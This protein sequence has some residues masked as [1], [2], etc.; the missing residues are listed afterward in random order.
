MPKLKSVELQADTVIWG[1]V[2]R[3]QY[4]N[5]VENKD[6][7]QLHQEARNTKKKPQKRKAAKEEKD[8]DSD[9]ADKDKNDDDDSNAGPSGSN[10]NDNPN[11]LPG[12][13]LSRAIRVQDGMHVTGLLCA[14]GSRVNVNA[15]EPGR[16]QLILGSGRHVAP[17]RYQQRTSLLRDIHW[18][19]VYITGQSYSKASDREGVDDHM[20]GPARASQSIMCNLEKDIFIIDRSALACI[21][22][23]RDGGGASEDADSTRAKRARTRIEDWPLRPR[24]LA[25]NLNDPASLYIYSYF[26]DK[27]ARHGDAEIRALLEEKKTV[28]F[29]SGPENC[30]HND[31]NAWRAKQN[32]KM[33]PPATKKVLRSSWWAFADFCPLHTS[34]NSFTVWPHAQDLIQTKGVGGEA[35]NRLR[36]WAHA[37]LNHSF[38]AGG[39]RVDR[40][41]EN[42]LDALV[43][44]RNECLVVG[45]L[46]GGGGQIDQIV[47]QIASGG[48][49]YSCGEQ[50]PQ[51]KQFG[52]LAIDKHQVTGLIYLH[53][54][55]ARG[56]ASSSEDS[57]GGSG[58]DDTGEG[59]N[60]S[61]DQDESSKPDSCSGED[62]EEDSAEDEEAGRKK[63]DKGK[64]KATAEN[65]QGRKEGSETDGDEEGHEAEGDGTGDATTSTADSD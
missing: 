42:T 27:A 30:D 12:E 41:R 19:M 65:D 54:G 58:G 44:C 33:R 39:Y 4:K 37:M 24:N 35:A 34:G 29:F 56:E 61:G 15:G 36:A 55:G 62:G 11:I 59:K 50:H 60:E 18:D 5:D 53:F 21:D 48:P 40:Y 26:V 1:L 64:G 25:F 2:Y 47:S 49:C 7:H 51:A 9:D 14:D 43:R 28:T 32:T 13:E 16:Y 6:L 38:L 3:D 8:D 57:S 63:K 31:C 52:H 45:H 46:R 10:N 23:P 20:M 17:D 22:R